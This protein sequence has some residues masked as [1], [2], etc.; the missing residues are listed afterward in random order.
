MSRT[1]I[2]PIGVGILRSL[3]LAQND[4]K[5]LGQ[6]LQDELHD[7]RDFR[8]E[9]AHGVF[10]AQTFQDVLQALADGAIVRRCAGLLQGLRDLI[11]LLARLRIALRARDDEVDDVVVATW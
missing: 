11:R 2:A 9:A 5:C 8:R 6:L 4:T 10:T 7:L 3:T 1:I